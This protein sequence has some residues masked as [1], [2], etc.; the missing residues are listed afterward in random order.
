MFFFFSTIVCIAFPKILTSHP[1]VLLRFFFFCTRNIY[2]LI[3][4]TGQQHQRPQRWHRYVHWIGLAFFP[5]FSSP[6]VFYT[7]AEG[8]LISVR[9]LQRSKF[10]KSYIFLICINSR[11]KEGKPVRLYKT[12]C[13]FNFQKFVVLLIHVIRVNV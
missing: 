1:P 3:R 7:L 9:S 6:I 12:I 13:T 4:A 2:G 5:S 8:I 10:Y 11:V